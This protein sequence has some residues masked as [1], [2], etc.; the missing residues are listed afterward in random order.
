M[1]ELIKKE[2]DAMSYEELLRRWRHAPIGSAI[3][4]GEV[5]EY[6]AERMS[7]MRAR[8]GHEAHVRASKSIGWER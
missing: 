5:G 1:D 3:F 8:V 6:Y 2:I 4:Q 7:Y